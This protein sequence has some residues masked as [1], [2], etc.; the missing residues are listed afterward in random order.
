MKI[1]RIEKP[2]IFIIFGASGDLA[3]LKIFP[4]LYSLAEQKRLPKKFHIVGFSRTEKTDQQFQK[5]FAKSVKE[6]HKGSVDKTILKELLKHVTYFTGQYK[7]KKDYFSFRQYLKKISGSDSI[8]KIAYFSVP[9]IVFKDIIKNLGESKKL[10]KED[11]RL[12]LEKPFGHDT[13]SAKSLFHFVGNYFDEESVFLLDHYLGKSAVQSILHLRHNNRILNKLIKGP[14]IANI[15]I[16][17]A[18]S[19][20]IQSR[21]GYFERIGTFK[22]MIQSHL[23]QILALTSMSIPIT[24]DGKSVHREKYSILSAIKFIESPSNIVLGQY[25]GYRK[26]EGVAKNSKTDTFAAL[27]LFIDRESWFKT[28]IYIRSGKKLNEKHTY[29]TIELKKNKFQSKDA[30]PNRIIFEL[31]PKERILIKLINQHGTSMDYQDLTTADS[32]ACTGDFCLPEHGLLLLDVIRN[33]KAN[34]LSFP[35]IIAAWR[36]ADKVDKCISKGKIKLEK[37]PQGSTGPKSQTRL[38]A[39]DGFQWYDPH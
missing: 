38:T 15:Q 32:I 7:I 17:A 29:V 30:E 27:R 20:G 11:I 16:T 5:E 19:V 34:F 31:Q 13:M 3:K 2:F 26:E 9:P 21:A 6:N 18:E 14:E 23:L 12:V 1:Y 8:S 36:L 10:K 35:E 22:D 25:E 37:Y 39:T 28:P 4:A 24:E 33:N